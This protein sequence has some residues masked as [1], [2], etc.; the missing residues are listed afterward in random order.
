MVEPYQAALESRAA[1]RQR[2]PKIEPL[3][4][5]EDSGP[6]PRGFDYLGVGCRAVCHQCRC[7]DH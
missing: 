2:H 5:L 6:L 4:P 3:G 7:W 1:A